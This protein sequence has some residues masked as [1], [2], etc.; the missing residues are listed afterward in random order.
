MLSLIK[1]RER[2]NIK[3]KKLKNALE[4]EEQC[5]NLNYG[6]EMKKYIVRDI[7]KLEMLE[8]VLESI[9]EDIKRLKK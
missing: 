9:S 2:L 6:R 4:E 7:G 3:Y 5:T 8:Y 1:L